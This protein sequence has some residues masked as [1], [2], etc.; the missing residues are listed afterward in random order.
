MAGFTDGSRLLCF[1]LRR[2]GILFRLGRSLVQPAKPFFLLFI[3]ALQLFLAFRKTVIRSSQCTLLR[4]HAFP[5][6]CFKGEPLCIKFKISH[7]EAESKILAA[8]PAAKRF[9]MPA[10]IYPISRRLP[11][12]RMWCRRHRMCALVYFTTGYCSRSHPLIPC[13]KLKIRLKPWS[14]KI[15]AA[16]VLRLPVAQ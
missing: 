5:S 8:L 1:F 16:T 9:I 3:L 13:L 12:R 6:S 11:D 14:I 4:R 2:V 7:P 10:M 15:L